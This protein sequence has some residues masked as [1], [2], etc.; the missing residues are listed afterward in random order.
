M[1]II[2]NIDGTD[3]EIT[4]TESELMLAALEYNNERL[5]QD[6]Q[7]KMYQKML[8]VAEDKGIYV[9]TNSFPDM[10]QHFLDFLVLDTVAQ[11]FNDFLTSYKKLLEAKGE[12]NAFEELCY[13]FDIDSEVTTFFDGYIPMFE[14]LRKKAI[15]LMRKRRIDMDTKDHL[16]S[17]YMQ[18]QLMKKKIFPFNDFI[19]DPKT[20]MRFVR[21]DISEWFT[22]I[23]Y[24]GGKL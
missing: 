5:G 9:D 3:R 20:M 11:D 24:P 14:Y 6:L 15:P 21:E 2:R 17:C 23:V 4:L 22:S 19:E 1:T 13:E 16:I 8:A 12:Q 7:E 10:K 18:E